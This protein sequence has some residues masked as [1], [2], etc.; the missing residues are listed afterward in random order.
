MAERAAIY[1]WWR[2]RHERDGSEDLDVQESR[3]RAYAEAARYTIVGTYRDTTEEPGDERPDLRRLRGAVWARRV[4]V[5]IATTPDRIFQDIER[6][7]RLANESRQL[8]VRLE[9]LESPVL[10]W[11]R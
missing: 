5:V 6:V 8:G 1:A 9:F 7:A 3:C 10:L 4:D 11:D 2:G